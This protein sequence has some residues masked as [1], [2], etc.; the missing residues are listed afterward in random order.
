MQNCTIKWSTNIKLDKIISTLRLSDKRLV[1][2]QG[3]QL[4]DLSPSA[5]DPAQALGGESAESQPLDHQRGP[6]MSLFFKRGILLSTGGDSH[7]WVLFHQRKNKDKEAD[8]A[9]A[10]KP[11]QF[12]NRGDG[13]MGVPCNILSMFV[14]VWDLVIVNIKVCRQ[15]SGWRFWSINKLSGESWERVA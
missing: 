9:K 15:G 11:C 8:E 14:Y 10:A 1:K 2:P 4:A 6:K 3:W 12:L 5:R 7:I 13:S